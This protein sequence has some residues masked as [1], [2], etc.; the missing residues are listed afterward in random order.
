M[1]A[2]HYFPA[3]VPEDARARIAFLE[4]HF[5]EEAGVLAMPTIGCSTGAVE[6]YQEE[7]DLVACLVGVFMRK[8]DIH[9]VY[10]WI[11]FCIEVR[12]GDI[13]EGYLSSP[14]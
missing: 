12:P 8:L 3:R 1:D 13:D 10:I 7:T 6:M 11:P 2:A 14:F 4:P 9:R 5:P